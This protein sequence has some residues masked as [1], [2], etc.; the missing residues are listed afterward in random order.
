M[1]ELDI[2][3]Y[4]AY[5]SNMDEEQMAYRCPGASV[6]GLCT[7]ED[8]KFVLDS[9]GV[10]SIIP[11]KGCHVTGMVWRVAK[12]DV[13]SLDRYEGISYGCYRKEYIKVSVNGQQREALVY[14]SNRDTANAGSRTGY[15]DRI[16]KAAK[17]HHFNQDYIE[18]LQ[19]WNR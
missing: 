12:R 17:H 4:F 2:D 19:S 18:E 8:M 1:R 10:A 11:Y 14:L 7:L 6:V 15:M 5:G 9:A 3:L 13:V 16:V